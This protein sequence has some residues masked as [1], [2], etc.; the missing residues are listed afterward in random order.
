[1][2]GLEN[3]VLQIRG[4][5]LLPIVQGG[6]GVGISGHR[7][8]GTV[9]RHGA[10]GTL[11]SVD[12]R[13]LY[14]DIM[15]RLRR[16]RDPAS[17]GAANVEALAREIAAARAIAGPSGFIAVNVM[18]ALSNYADL[19]VEACRSGANAIVSGAGLPLE[20][21]ELTEPYPDVALIPILSEERGVRVVMKKWARRGRMPD[22]IVLEHPRYAG[23]HLGATRMAD[24]DDTRFDFARVLA[25]IRAEGG[26]SATV[27]LIVAGGINSREKM[28]AAFALGANGVQ[29]G[30][31]FAVTVEC[32]AHPNF[33]KVLAEAL[34]ADIVTFMS[35]AGL[36]ARAVLTPWLKRY[37]QKEPRLRAAARPDP[38]GITCPSQVQCLSACGFKDGNPAAGQFC[39]ETQLAAAQRGSVDKGLFFRGSESLP[40]GEQIKSVADLLGHLLGEPAPTLALG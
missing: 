20:L 14:P 15:Q 4:H 24:I 13:R 25:A 3:P 18:R 16:C 30:T 5:R 26:E 36:P 21:P 37:L 8:A 19:V 33:K 2:T 22:A 28:Q 11:A 40:F 32:D 7:L 34:P 39:I 29:I 17:H 38:S 31:P 10:V 35:P 27:P 1:M 6:M 9:A 23:G 12:L